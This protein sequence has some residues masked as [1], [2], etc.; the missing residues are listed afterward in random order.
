VG[1][2]SLAE[3]NALAT[4]S[5]VMEESYKE[6]DKPQC[7]SFKDDTLTPVGFI[8]FLLPPEMDSSPGRV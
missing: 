4:L 3:C 7:K 6:A 8:K 2:V 1:K 5:S